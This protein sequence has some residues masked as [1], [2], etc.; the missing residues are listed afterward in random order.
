V[1]ATSPV[2][3]LEDF[4]Q[5]ITAEVESLYHG[6]HPVN[7]P[8]VSEEYRLS[9]YVDIKKIFPTHCRVF[10]SLVFSDDCLKPGKSEGNKLGSKKLSVVTFFLALCR[11][12]SFKL[13]TNW[14]LVETLAYELKRLPKLAIQLA[15][16]CRFD[17]S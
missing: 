4:L 12:K 8:L 14:A 9:L 7:A 2:V 17:M 11:Q 5:L 10:D 16:R 3:D 6:F 1:T 15:T 13:L